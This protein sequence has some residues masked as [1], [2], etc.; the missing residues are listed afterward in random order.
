MA[1]A[2][3]IALVA[4]LAFRAAAPGEAWGQ[5]PSVGSDIVPLALA[6]A[7]LVGCLSVAGAVWVGPLLL[8]ALVF[9]I[10]TTSTG[11]PRSE[12]GSSSLW[13]P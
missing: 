1:A 7:A 2:A 13:S 10:V 5:T 8:G 6:V 12:R 3:L 11:P 4:C 9:A